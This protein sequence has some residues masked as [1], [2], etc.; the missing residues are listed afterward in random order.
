MK[1]MKFYA[2]SGRIL[3]GRVV[4]I[5]DQQVDCSMTL[6]MRWN[7][8]EIRDRGEKGNY[9]IRQSNPSTQYFLHDVAIR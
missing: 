5:L 9:S 3:T 7:F 1:E 6:S 4:V 2:K 8:T